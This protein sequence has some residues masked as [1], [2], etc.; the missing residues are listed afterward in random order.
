MY[1]APEVLLGQ[2]YNEKIDVFSFGIIMYELFGGMVI[3]S[4]VALQGEAELLL[5][6]AKKVTLRH[7]HD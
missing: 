1:M 5:D 4:R 6:Y 7:C 3:L 2:P